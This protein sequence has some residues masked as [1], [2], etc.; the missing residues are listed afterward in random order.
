MPDCFHCLRIRDE[1]VGFYFVFE[2][3]QLL[4]TVFNRFPQYQEGNLVHNPRDP[5]RGDEEKRCPVSR[6]AFVA[7]FSIELRC[8]VPRVSFQPERAGQDG[9]C[10]LF[11]VGDPPCGFFSASLMPPHQGGGTLT[12]YDTAQGAAHA[13]K[14]H[15]DF[16]FQ[17]SVLSLVRGWLFSGP[18]LRDG[19]RSSGTP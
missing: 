10:L 1:C 18:N 13:L 5:R 6:Q 8:D 16:G 15:E 2:E 17:Q 3:I 14:R 11:L 4:E 19:R 12:K 9:G 7:F